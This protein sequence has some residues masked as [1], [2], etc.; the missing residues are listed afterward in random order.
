MRRQRSTNSNGNKTQSKTAAS[1]ATKSKTKATK[2]KNGHENGSDEQIA[3]TL[4]NLVTVQQAIDD[5]LVEGQLDGRRETSGPDT[6]TKKRKPIKK[7]TYQLNHED[8]SRLNT[9]R[10]LMELLKSK[11]IKVRD[12]ISTL[13]YEEE[14]VA[15]QVELVKLQRWVQEKGKR[16]AILFEGRDAAGKGGTIRRFTEHLNPRSIRVVALPKPTAE[17]CGQWY[18]QRYSKQLPNAGE[19]VFFDRSWYN[20]AVV[21]PV[22][23]FCTTREYE[24]FMQQV[25]EYEHMLYED[26]II[27]VKFWFSISKSEQLTRFRSR[28]INPLKQWKLSAID[29]KAQD[30]WDDYTHYKELMFS[31]THTSFSPWIIVKSNNKKLARLES[32]RHVLNIMDYQGKNEAKIRIAPDP[33]IVTRFHRNVIRLD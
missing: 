11:N 21:E 9:N 3:Q 2:A 10:G 8:L 27:I 17:E 30:L 28:R 1:G 29:E 25:P 24:R 7:A 31:K 33:D 18:F 32:I 4:M 15:L 19:I 23:E 16:V 22:N 20:R 5:E 26:G 12:I 14:L 6:A 13:K